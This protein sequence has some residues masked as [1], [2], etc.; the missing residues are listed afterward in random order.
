MSRGE[1]E[2][3]EKGDEQATRWIE[4]NCRFFVLLWGIQAYER[5]DE[6]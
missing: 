6:R 4:M 5:R 3:V 1:G 2:R